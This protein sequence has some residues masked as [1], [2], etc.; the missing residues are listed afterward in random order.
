LWQ[1]KAN[2]NLAFENNKLTT[3]TGSVDKL[4]NT[5]SQGKLDVTKGTINA[6]FDK[7]GNLSKL[8]GGADS[9]SYLSK[10]GDKLDVKGLGI[11]VNSG[12]NGIE[13]ATATA[14]Q[15]NYLSN[16]G[17]LLNVTNGKASLTRDTQ[18][19]ISNLSGSAEKI[20][21]GNQKGDNI[22]ASGTEINV[23]CDKN[24]LKDAQVKVGTLDYNNLKGDKLNL[25]NGSATITRDN[26]G[27]ISSI[28]GSAEKL[29]GLDKNGNTLAVN[30]LKVGLVSTGQ[31]SYNLNAS[32][33]KLNLALPK[34]ELNINA[35][36]LRVGLTDTQMTMHVDSAE[37]IK[38]IESDLKVKV[39][40]LDVIVDKTKEGNFKIFRFTI[41]KS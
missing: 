5:S 3:L 19:N 41:S 27:L 16:K 7:D 12:K 8:T 20:A 31:D 39:E 14:G 13:S 26:K 11:E 30:G 17:D 22:I 34:Q 40:N 35:N 9:L 10:K 32:A 21:F 18:G 28:N 36:N 1:K 2:V 4:S 15:I 23:N 38:K 37:I 25:V 33:D 6:N 24:G 29:N